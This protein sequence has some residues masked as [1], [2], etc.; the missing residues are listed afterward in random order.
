MVI[1]FAAYLLGACGQSPTAGILPTVMVLPTTAP[2]DERT[3]IP[4]SIDTS[5]PTP[6]QIAIVTEP[7]INVAQAAN[8]ATLPPTW[9]PTDLPTVT[10]TPT[11]SET[12]TAT[13]TATIT[14]THTLTPTPMGN[15]VVSGEDGVNLRS[16]PGTDYNPP[17]TTLDPAT[18]LLLAGRTS[19]NQWYEV[20]TFEGLQGWVSATYVTS[21]ENLNALPITCISV[22]GLRITDRTRQIFADGQSRGNRPNV[23]TKVGDSLTDAQPF[24]ISYADVRA[25]D[26]GPYTY[27][28]ETISYFSMSPRSGVDNSWVNPSLA[29]RGSYTAPAVLS[30]AEA[31]HNLCQPNESPIA[32]EYRLTQPSISI[33]LLGSVDMQFIEVDE[34]NWAMEMIVNETISRGIIPVLNTFPSTPEFLWDKSLQFNDAIRN[35]AA[36]EQIPL[37][38][39]WQATQALPGHGVSSEDH[40]HLSSRGDGFINLNG[41]ENRFGLTMRNLVTLQALE[42]LRREV[43]TS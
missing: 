8:R 19:D 10:F 9:T 22:P 39:L 15:A 26:L 18:E 4:L 7:P 23:F 5:T 11:M 33:I 30:A 12:P 20:R 35:L 34:F 2:N 21:R 3:P 41:E 24:L 13:F 6:I 28:S 43:L 37:I 14:P 16:G 29:A 38:D 32:C 42:L 17:L 1:C 27:L 40:F 25:H 31:N 36:R